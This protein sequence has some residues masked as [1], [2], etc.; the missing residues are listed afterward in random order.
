MASEV[1]ERIARAIM[2]AIAES[3][4]VPADQVHHFAIAYCLGS[5]AI[6]VLSN[7]DGVHPTLTMFEQGIQRLLEQGGLAGHYVT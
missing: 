2:E 5:D 6:G 1:S 7:L 4:G 3:C